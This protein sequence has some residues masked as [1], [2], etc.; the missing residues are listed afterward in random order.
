MELKQTCSKSEASKVGSPISSIAKRKFLTFS[1]NWNAHKAAPS[2]PASESYAPSTTYKQNSYN[3]YESSS[4][5]NSTISHSESSDDT[6]GTAP[7]WTLLRTLQRMIPLRNAI[8]NSSSE[9]SSGKSLPP[10]APTIPLNHSAASYLL[11]AADHFCS[12]KHLTF[13]HM[14]ITLCRSFNIFKS[15]RKFT[16]AYIISM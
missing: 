16:T 11:K 7:G 14:Y 4:K 1:K 15:L 10:I 8:L 3:Y 13:Q 5:V 12:I 9:G 6:F 2:D